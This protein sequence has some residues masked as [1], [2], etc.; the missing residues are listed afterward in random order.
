MK[1][2]WEKTTWNNCVVNGC[3]IFQKKGNIKKTIKRSLAPGGGG[4]ARLREGGTDGV[5]HRTSLFMVT[6][7]LF[8]VT[9]DTIR[10]L[11]S[12]SGNQLMQLMQADDGVKGGFG[13]WERCTDDRWYKILIGR[14]IE[15]DVILTVLWARNWSKSSDDQTNEDICSWTDMQEIRTDM[16]TF[17]SRIPFHSIRGQHY[18]KLSMKVCVP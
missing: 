10:L 5:F 2:L 11:K 12:T 13:K 16:L 8:M 15:D 1:S 4:A 14:Q 17:P 6:K 3:C 9:N 7:S 18:I